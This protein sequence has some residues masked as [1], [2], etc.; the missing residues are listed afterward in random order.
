MRFDVLTLFPEMFPGYLSQSLLNLAIERGLV[1]VEVHNIRDWA[2][3]KHKNVD[4]RPFGGGPGMVL[5]PEPVVECVEAVQQMDSSPGRVIMLTPSG[6]RFDQR[7]AEEYSNEQRLVLLC[8]RYEGFDQRVV[9]ILQPDELSIGDFV[10]NGGEV[11][12]MVVV[13][14]VV[15]LVPG[16]LGDEQSNKQDSFS[17]ENR[18]LEFAQ[19]TRPREYRGH[20]VPEVLLSGNHPEIA[21]WRKQNSLERT[22]QRRAD[23]LPGNGDK[24][25]DNP[26]NSADGN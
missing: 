8:G 19:Y 10:L 20:A 14:A 4:D 25:S 2:K 11:A 21:E 13:D 6:R 5:S 9:D 18:L 3:G 1:S 23:L 15:R 26:G 24:P 7:V 22:R 12:A 16:V 17:S